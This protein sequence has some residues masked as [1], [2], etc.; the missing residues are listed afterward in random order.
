MSW[1]S[2]TMSDGTVT[3]TSSDPSSG[4]RYDLMM[5]EFQAPA[6]GSITYAALEDG[7]ATRVTWKDSGTFGKNPVLR[8][9]GPIM[10]SMLGTYFDRGLENVKSLV[11]AQG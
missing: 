3:V 6:H 11:E 5:K 1:K 10:E 4:L 2:E 7:Q 8:L 9:M